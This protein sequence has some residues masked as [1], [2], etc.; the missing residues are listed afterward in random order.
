MLHQ[1]PFKQ[2]DLSLLFS[3]S[4]IFSEFVQVSNQLVCCLTEKVCVKPV[5]VRHPHS[6]K[7]TSPSRPKR[8]APSGPIGCD[9]GT[10]SSRNSA[11][12]PGERG[13]QL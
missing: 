1:H 6:S 11:A 8:I 10:A 9:F 4:T 13:R 5:L 2:G 12:K 3:C 7:M